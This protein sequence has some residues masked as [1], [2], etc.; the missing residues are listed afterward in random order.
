MKQEPLVE[1]P[2]SLIEWLAREVELSREE[3]AAGPLHLEM[4]VPGAPRI[5]GRN[6]CV[7]PPTTLV[8][9][10]LMATKSESSIILSADV[11]RMPDLEERTQDWPTI[12]VYNEARDRD[13]VSAAHVSG[14]IVT[15]W[16]IRL[17]E[18]SFVFRKRQLIIVTALGRQ[19]EALRKP[20]CA[21]RTIANNR[22]RR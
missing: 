8:V 13:P 17:E 1:Q 9:D 10:G 4:I 21:R 3:P 19:S 15:K 22:Q 7:E 14:E 16:C 18:W 5:S 6:D 11:I 20:L 12:L 2:V